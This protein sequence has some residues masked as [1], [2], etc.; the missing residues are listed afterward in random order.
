MGSCLETVGKILE[1]VGKILATCWEVVRKL[2]GN[3]WKLLGNSGNLLGN[4]G[5]LLGNSW[6]KEQQM[7]PCYFLKKHGQNLIILFKEK[8]KFSTN[9]MVLELLGDS[10]VLLPVLV[11]DGLHLPE[12]VLQQSSAYQ[13]VHCWENRGLPTSDLQGYKFGLVSVECWI[14]HTNDR[15]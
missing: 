11:L 1:T 8:L 10:V 15:T 4:S 14:L 3:S 12:D 6:K 7:H 9:L 13:E 2:L 5:K